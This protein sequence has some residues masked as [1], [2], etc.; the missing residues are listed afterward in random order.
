MSLCITTRYIGTWK[1][2]LIMSFC[3]SLLHYDTLIIHLYDFICACSRFKLNIYLLMI[4][5]RYFSYFH[6][7]VCACLIHVLT[8]EY[9]E[10]PSL[11]GHNTYF[12]VMQEHL[13]GLILWGV[14]FLVQIMSMTQIMFCHTIS[15]FLV[16][17]HLHVGICSTAWAPFILVIFFARLKVVVFK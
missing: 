11:Q 3:I 9:F 6:F 2:T 5:Q 13:Y 7:H 8:H 17:S 12:V 4:S 14:S 1:Y 15:I 16:N 10:K